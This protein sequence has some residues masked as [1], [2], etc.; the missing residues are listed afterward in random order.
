MHHQI[1]S[2]KG[3]ENFIIFNHLDTQRLQSEDI[4]NLDPFRLI[5]QQGNPNHWGYCIS[6]EKT[7]KPDKQSRE[8]KYNSLCICKH[9]VNERQIN[10]CH[11]SNAHVSCKSVAKIIK[12]NNF[13]FAV[14]QSGLKGYLQWS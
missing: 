11:S 9:R 8:L 7:I 2:N 12:I 4:Q 14:E 10:C 13:F 5:N 3:L 1:Y 6:E